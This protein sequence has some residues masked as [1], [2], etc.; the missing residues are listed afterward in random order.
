M[1]AHKKALKKLKEDIK[2]KEILDDKISTLIS[3]LY[4]ER[5][6]EMEREKKFFLTDLF[7]P[8]KARALCWKTDCS[9]IY[10]RALFQGKYFINKSAKHLQRH[11][12]TRHENK[13]L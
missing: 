8:Q 10:L 2:K 9:F 1:N 4:K 3:D 5:H 11:N 12:K 6:L 13:H 7:F